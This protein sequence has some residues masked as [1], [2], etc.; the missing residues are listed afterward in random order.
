MITYIENP[1]KFRGEKKT[2]DDETNRAKNKKE[3]NVVELIRRQAISKR[4]SFSHIN[5]WIT[6]VI[7]PPPPMFPAEKKYPQNFPQCSG[8]RRNT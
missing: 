6:D 7:S 3:I 5:T 4:R 2:I 8:L 1:K